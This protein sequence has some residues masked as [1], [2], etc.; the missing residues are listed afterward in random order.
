DL[1]D[2]A[3]YTE[4]VNSEIDSLSSEFILKLLGYILVVFLVGFSIL[5]VIEKNYLLNSTKL[6][7]SEINID[8]LT[9]AFSRRC[10]EKNLTTF[11]KHYKLTG[12]NP[13]IMVF[14]VD[15][16]KHINDKYGHK[17]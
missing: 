5:Y 17:V 14:D 16:F 10:G 6:L 11:F 13:A 3:A 15:D 8:T 4:K 1:D 2:I 9:K 7:E 12:E